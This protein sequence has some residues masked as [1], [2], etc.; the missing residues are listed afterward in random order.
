MDALGLTPVLEENQP[1][2]GKGAV[3]FRKRGLLNA[4]CHGALHAYRDVDRRGRFIRVGLLTPATPSA[5]SAAS[6][7][8]TGFR[9]GR[10]WLRRLPFRIFDGPDHQSVWL[11]GQGRLLSV[12]AER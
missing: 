12:D 5:A 11:A 2:Q 7:G 1:C 8:H 6:A 10:G 9:L 3:A 4:L